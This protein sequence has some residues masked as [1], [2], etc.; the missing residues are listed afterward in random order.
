MRAGAGTLYRKIFNQ[1]AFS[2]FS[3][4]A[5]PEL[6]AGRKLQFCGADKNSPTL[7][8]GPLG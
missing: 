1:K 2:L 5:P 6:S 4:D 8:N 7:P 3:C